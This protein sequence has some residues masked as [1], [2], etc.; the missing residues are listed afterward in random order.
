MYKKDVNPFLRFLGFNE[1]YTSYEKPNIT[2]SRF[3]TERKPF[4]INIKIL[5]GFNSPDLKKQ[6]YE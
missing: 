6:K 4:Y 3:F 2:F 5:L 1:N